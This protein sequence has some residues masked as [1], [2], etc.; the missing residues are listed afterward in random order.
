M[1]QTAAK[2]L[3][4][5]LTFCAALFLF[6]SCSTVKNYPNKP[7]VY[8]TNITLNGKFSTDDRKDL[9]SKLQQQLHDSVV[10]RRKQTLGF[11]NTLKNP[12]VYDSS[13]ADKSVQYMDALLN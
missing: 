5:L 8:E 10:T 9:Q 13:N 6:F 2:P 3:T 7:F 1:I 4:Q 11:W 12:P